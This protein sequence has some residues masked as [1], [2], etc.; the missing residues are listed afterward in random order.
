[1]HPRSGVEVY[2]EE[3]E[4]RELKG[5]YVCV[6]GKRMER[7]ERGTWAGRDVEAKGM[8]KGK[9]EGKCSHKL[10]DWVGGIGPRY[11]ESESKEKE[12]TNQQY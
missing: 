10:T 3:K 6:G 4:G 9:G 8:G 7:E 2:V 12:T 11:S 5:V 1:M